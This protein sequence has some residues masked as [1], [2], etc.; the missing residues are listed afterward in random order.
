M[1]NIQWKAVVVCM[2]VH[3]TLCCVCLQLNAATSTICKYTYI[4]VVLEVAL[5]II[6]SNCVCSALYVYMWSVV[7]LSGWILML[8][9]SEIH[10]YCLVH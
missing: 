2:S 9:S 10:L 8:G 5:T 4:Y 6:T 7:F 1:G 3:S